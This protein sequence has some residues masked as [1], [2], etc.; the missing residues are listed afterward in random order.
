VNPHPIAQAKATDNFRRH[1]NILRSLN[2]IA[3]PIPEEPEALARNFDNT[4]AELRFSLQLAILRR[5]AEFVLGASSLTVAL[6][7]SL[8]AFDIGRASLFNSVRRSIQVATLS[9][10]ATPARAIMPPGKSSTGTTWTFRRGVGFRRSLVFG[11]FAHKF[12]DDLNAAEAADCQSAAAF[13]R[14]QLRQQL[15]RDI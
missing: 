15:V 5:V 7:H 13:S 11:F 3:F 10:R 1:K 8:L 6:L 2:K 9:L 4:V 14:W 12:R